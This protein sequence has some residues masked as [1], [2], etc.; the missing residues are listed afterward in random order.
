MNE[1]RGFEIKRGMGSEFV[2]RF[3][4]VSD[5]FFGGIVFQKSAVLKHFFFDGPVHSFGQCV[6]VRVAV[7]GHADADFERFQAFDIAITAVLRPPV[8]VVKQTC[9]AFFARC[10]RH[11][12]G[13]LTAFGRQ[14]AP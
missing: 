4:G 12:E 9:E 3:D 6:F 13:G 2:V 14:A 1:L 5:G 11:F 7:E 8:G 10:Y